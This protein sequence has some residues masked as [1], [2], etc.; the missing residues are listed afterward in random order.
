MAYMDYNATTPLAAEA[1]EAMLPW[2]GDGFGNPS[3]IHA[4]GRLAR[5][6][7]DDARECLAALLG[8]RPHEI[9]FTSGGT[10]SCNLGVLGLARAARQHGRHVITQKT[11]HHAVLHA[12]E[13][14]AKEGFDVTWL[15]VDP[16]G[17]VDPGA[18]EAAIRSDTILVSVM[19]ANNETGTI[20]PVKELAQICASRGIAFHTDAIQSF[21][22]LP[23]SLD[24]GIT[25]ASFAAHK[26]Y[27]P[28]GAGFLWLRSGHSIERIGQGGSHENGRR[29]GTE[30]VPAIVGMA[31]AA[32]ITLA[33]LESEALR[34]APMREA[35]WE[36][37]VKI[38]PY[39]VR[40]GAPATT[41]PNTLNVSFPGCDGE[42]LI[43]GLDLEGI[44]VSSGSACM[45]GTMQAS[46]VVLAM[47]A[48]AKT[49]AA[50]IRFSLGR[51][52]TDNDIAACA[53][54]LQKTLARQPRKT[55]AP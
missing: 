33:S 45:V 27:G 43:I 47:G 42:A 13:Q 26:F 29:P 6:A 19:H 24:P 30:N 22:K 3:S 32:E 2:L 37:I 39:A 34:L 55:H 31:V 44:S 10:E 50:T 38:A 49:A 21:G 54:A 17:L 36:K 52:T 9:I 14:L 23:V 1:R 35:L 4:E 41:L 40:N 18:L 20:Q 25:A 51:Q 28:K 8:A 46:H 15:D 12:C 7:V 16:H 48:D 11:E 53:A 5:A